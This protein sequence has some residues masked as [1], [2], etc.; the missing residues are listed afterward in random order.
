MPMHRRLSC[1]VTS[2]SV[3]TGLFWSGL[4]STNQ[5]QKIDRQIDRWIDG[6]IE[7]NGF[8]V[9]SSS[10]AARSLLLLSCHVNL[11]GIQAMSYHYYG[12]ILHPHYW[13]DSAQ[14]VRENQIRAIC[15]SSRLPV[16]PLELCVLSAH[17]TWLLRPT[18]LLCRIL[19]K[20]LA[21]CCWWT[22]KGQVSSS[23]E[24]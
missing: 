16:C 2:G 21:V 5:V 9:C 20:S 14:Q 8:V 11:N 15:G 13:L 18:W 19:V 1:N 10:A 23:E 24:Y 12:N 4:V 17:K 3:Q 6:Q 22:G 7:K